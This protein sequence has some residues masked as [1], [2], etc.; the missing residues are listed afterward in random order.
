MDIKE[1]QKLVLKFRDDRNWG[2]FTTPK[3]SAL[4]LVAEVGE[5]IEHFKWHNEK[6]M[7]EYVEKNRREIGEELSDVLF[8]VLQMS[9]DLQID[10]PKAFVEKMKKNEEKYPVELWK[11]KHS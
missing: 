8:W 1:L 10:L 3:D 5:L 6:E 2:P 7:Q 4:A 9:H 11:R